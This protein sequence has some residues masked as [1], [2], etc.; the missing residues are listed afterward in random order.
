MMWKRCGFLLAAAGHRRVRERRTGSSPVHRARRSRRRRG[1]G[2]SGS[3]RLQERGQERSELRGSAPKARRRRRRARSK[4]RRISRVREGRHHR[5]DR[6]RSADCD[7]QAP[8]R[9]RPVRRGEDASR[10]RARG[11]CEE[12]RRAAARG[13]HPGRDEGARRRSQRCRSGV[14]NGSED[15]GAVGARARRLRTIPAHRRSPGGSRKRTAAGACG[16]TRRRAREP[17][18]GCVLSGAGTLSGRGAVLQARRGRP[19]SEIAIDPGARRLP[20]RSAPLRRC[21]SGAGDCA[22]RRRAGAGCAIAHGGARIRHRVARQGSRP[23]RARAEARRDGRWPRIEI[24]LS[25]GRGTRGPTRLLRHALR[26]TWIPA[27][28]LRSS[29][30]GRFPRARDG[31]ARRSTC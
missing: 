25:R 24:A 23:A 10:R 1:Q 5:R 31:T 4:R 16:G 18:D 6:C 26:S 3:D 17:R 29:S 21:A 12:H 27:R 15:G 14:Q 13:K 28:P 2:R 22:G 19:S 8:A 9:R 30:W 11:R 20:G 7:G